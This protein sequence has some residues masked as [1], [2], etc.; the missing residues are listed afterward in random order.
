[1]G[2]SENESESENESGSVG[3]LNSA[4][5]I[6]SSIKS[7]GLLNYPLP[8]STEC[9]NGGIMSSLQATVYVCG[10]EY[11][12][13]ETFEERR[14]TEKECWKGDTQIHACY[15]K[16]GWSGRLCQD[17][18]GIKCSLLATADEKWEVRV[19]I[20][21]GFGGEEYLWGEGVKMANIMHKNDL[22]RIKSKKLPRPSNF[23]YAF[24]DAKNN[25]K[26]AYEVNI[27]A[28]ISFINI[29]NFEEE[30]RIFEFPFEE[31]KKRGTWNILS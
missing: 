9:S 14:P 24:V 29:N 6:L 12:S 30:Y 20:E 1:M 26:L 28:Y 7:T 27:T 13:Q 5:W 3:S 23:E 31:I 18:S 4:S 15:C 17:W 21:C 10:G 2:R 16:A 11:V 8:P 25:F 19:Q 22:W